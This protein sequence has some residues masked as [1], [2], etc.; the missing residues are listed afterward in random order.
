MKKLLLSVLILMIALAACTAGGTETEETAATPTEASLEEAP[1]ATDKPPVP[2]AEPTASNI[3][4]TTPTSEPEPTETAEPT[5]TEENQ[6]TPQEELPSGNSGTIPENV[7]MPEGAVIAFS[8]TGGFAGLTNNWV[9]FPDGRV[10][11]N[12]IDQAQLGSKRIEQLI[13]DLAAQ[14]FFEVEHRTEPGTFCC[15]F[16]DYALAVQTAARQNYISYSDGD[17]DLPGTLLEITRLMREITEE[18][19]LR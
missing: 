5:A 13:S 11:L 18:A 8:Q 17:P 4:T 12:G 14:G 10:T 6:P 3:P 9:F 2:T 1:T 19:Q 7:Q 16:F 15:D